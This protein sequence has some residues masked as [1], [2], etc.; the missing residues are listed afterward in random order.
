MRCQC[1]D[2]Y[3][4]QVEAG[5]IHFGN[6]L[7]AYIQTADTGHGEVLYM[8][9]ISVQFIFDSTGSAFIDNELLRSRLQ[10]GQVVCNI[11]EERC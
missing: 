1:V 10:R 4:V 5:G 8:I 3:E 9:H 7:I 6:V 11:S 2:V